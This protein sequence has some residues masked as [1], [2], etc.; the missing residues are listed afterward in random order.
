MSRRENG[1]DGENYELRKNAR[2]VRFIIPLLPLQADF[3]LGIRW[4]PLPR[5]RVPL[6]QVHEILG[7][8]DDAE[9]WRQ[10]LPKAVEP[11]GGKN[12]ENNSCSS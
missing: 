2:P 6:V 1:Q 4:M 3:P 11:V 10:G 9:T 5:F 8:K 7:K 12:Q